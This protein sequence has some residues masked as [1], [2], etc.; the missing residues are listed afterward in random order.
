MYN[1]FLNVSLSVLSQPFIYIYLDHY[2]IEIISQLNRTHKEPSNTEKI[3]ACKSYLPFHAKHASYSHRFVQTSQAIHKTSSVPF[4]PFSAS[5]K[6]HFIPLRESSPHISGSD[7]CS[8]VPA[9][10]LRIKFKPYLNLSL[11]HLASWRICC[12]SALFV[13][14][15]ADFDKTTV[16]VF[17]FH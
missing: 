16:D 8:C 1:N 4:K 14:K 5:W 9:H 2:Y 10:P 15:S 11:N 17:C 13:I 3:H 12:Y 7:T 6:N